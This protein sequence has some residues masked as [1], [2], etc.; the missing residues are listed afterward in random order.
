MIT[1]WCTTLI[2]VVAPVV[3]ASLALSYERR[4]RR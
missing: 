4:T 1:P 3:A 2:A